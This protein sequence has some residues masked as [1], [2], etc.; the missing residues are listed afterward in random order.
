MQRKFSKP[1]YLAHRPNSCRFR[2]LRSLVCLSPLLSTNKRMATRFLSVMSKK[3]DVPRA[4]RG[5]HHLAVVCLNSLLD[6]KSYDLCPQN[7]MTTM[8]VSV[9]H[10]EGEK[11]HKGG[12]IHSALSLKC[13]CLFRHFTSKP[14]SPARIATLFLLFFCYSRQIVL[15]TLNYQHKP[16]C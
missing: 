7:H 13:T 6:F 3:C 16:G 14:F 15:K 2:R 8:G 5:S 9:K 10:E 4:E 11:T 12:S 1:R